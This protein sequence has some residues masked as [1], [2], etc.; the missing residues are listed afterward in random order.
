M[1]RA[2]PE[3][4]RVVSAKRVGILDAGGGSKAG[5]LMRSSGVPN[6]ATV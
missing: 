1:R 5:G 4:Y 2:G 3:F 6:I